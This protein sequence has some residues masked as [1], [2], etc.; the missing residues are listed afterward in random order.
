MLYKAL[1]DEKPI[2][3]DFIYGD[4]EKDG[5]L[6][7]L[8]GQQ[9]LTTLFLLH[10]Y[11][12]Q[13]EDIV[14]NEWEFLKRFSYETRV[15]SQ[16]FCRH[17]LSFKPVFSSISISD[18][19]NDEAWF[20]L[21]WE[22]D[23]TV[24]AML[25]M[26]DDIHA[27]FKDTSGIWE[28]LTGDA[29]T[30]Y[31]LPLE[32]MGVSDEL[33]IKM[34]SRGK[35]LSP[36]EHFKAELELRMK[37]VDSESAKRIITSMDREWT[38]MLWP[39]R[40]SSAGS[41]EADEVVDDEFL[42]YVHFVCDIISYKNGGMEIKDEFEMIEKLFSV[43]CPNARE[44]MQRLENWLNFWTWENK[45]EKVKLDVKAFFESYIST[46]EHETGK[47]IMDRKPDDVMPNLFNECCRCYGLRS[48]LRPMFSLGQTLMLYAFIIYLEN[49]QRVT[50][51]DFRRRLRIVNNLVRNSEYTLRAEFMSE[52][53]LQ[54]DKIVL[55]GIVEQVEEGK[56]RF[57]SRQM[58]EEARKL[59]W[60]FAN[61]ELAETLFKLEDHRFLN[62][63]ITVVG[64]E[65]VD[66]CDR[67]YSLFSCDLNKINLA[68]LAT[69]DYFEED[70][71][72]YQIG[73]SH[74]RASLNVW[75]TLFGPT[76]KNDGLS[77]VLLCLLSEYEE[78]SNA[79]LDDIT[80]SYLNNATEFPVRYYMIKY[81]SMLPNMFGKYYWR[82]HHSV[83]T[84]SYNVI[85]MMTEFNFGQN[86]D[87]FLAALHKEIGGDSAGYRISNYA[88]SDYN[89]IEGKCSK[90]E[91]PNGMYLTLA[92]NQY[93]IRQEDGEIVEL[94]AVKQ[95]NGVDIEDRVEV[96]LQLLKKH[97]AE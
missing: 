5:N 61:P 94:Y 86:Y 30:F 10:Y 90:L 24:Q 81:P 6:I 54:V 38:D 52:L 65:H 97:M 66:W 29:V 22:N 64:L 46:G 95:E 70:R 96:G 60:T 11:V 9:R 59:K 57:Q 82:G 16:E 32:K 67:F 68:L 33:Y 14:Q 26:L 91:M 1:A 47:I 3:L 69:G 50:D 79:L 89:N 72:R 13:H 27:K 48:G 63:C 58:E 56:A 43:K 35:P 92:D 87:M 36:F 25:V 93:T 51:S 84:N 44:N 37:E 76:R 62:G 40:K 85:M 83:G 45:E 55:D 74:P 42:R 8:D 75:R 73:T 7:P 18:Q 4:V 2:T 41:Q 71:W 19:I 88:Y 78:F 31:F 34:N 23:P 15:S 20:M 80:K 12:A 17:L 53:L 21:E 49:R 28:R 39:F 77:R